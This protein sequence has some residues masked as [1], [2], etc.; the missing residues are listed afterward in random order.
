MEQFD[1]E[2][3]ESFDEATEM[4]SEGENKK[5]IS[6]GTALTTLMK[7]RVFQPETLVNL[8]QLSEDHRYIERVDDE[9]RIGA[10]TPLRDVERSDVVADAVPVVAETASKIASIRVRNVAT[11]GGNLAHSDPDL[12]LPPVLSGLGADI[13]VHGPDGERTQPLT[14]FIQGY[15]Q[16]DLAQNELVKAVH[17]PI[18]PDV[19]GVYLKHRALSEADW[20]CVGVAAFRRADAVPE[21]YMNAVADTPIFSIDDLDSVF[22][23]GITEDA[24]EAAGDLAHEQCDPIGDAR[25]SAWYKR[26]MAKEMTERSL[27]EV[28]GVGATLEGVAEL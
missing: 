5:P 14:E 11:I 15:Y 22:A 1:M 24:I 20:P 27:R 17:I 19:E 18:D 13:V 7:E 8:R 2:F 6:G 25:G 3:P 23:D 12:D 21:V 26:E 10:L 28:T 9:I 16:T 4:L